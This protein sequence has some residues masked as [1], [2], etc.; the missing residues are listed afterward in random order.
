MTV[1]AVPPRVAE[2]AP[3]A[4]KAAPN[5]ARDQLSPLRG[6]AAREFGDGRARLRLGPNI[7]A[8]LRLCTRT[9]SHEVLNHEE[10]GLHQEPRSFVCS[11]R[12]L[13]NG[14]FSRGRR[15]AA[16]AAARPARVPSAARPCLRR[17]GDDP[18]HRA[19][20]WP[21]VEGWRRPRAHAEMIALTQVIVAQDP[22]RRRTSRTR[23]TPSRRH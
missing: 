2:R 11:R 5:L 13:G 15:L 23:A 12:F 14:P 22:L 1:T 20:A 18:L 16:P 6:R 7:A 17:A 19:Q 4:R 3:P 9:P 21:G 8:M 10:P